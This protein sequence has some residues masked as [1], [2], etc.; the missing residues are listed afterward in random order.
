MHCI[1]L[2]RNF[3]KREQKLSIKNLWGRGGGGHPSID[4]KGG[5]MVS[6]VPPLN[7]AP[8]T[9]LATMAY[10]YA[11][12]TVHVTIFSTGAIFRTVSNFTEL[13]ALTQTTVLMYSCS[14]G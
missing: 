2:V 13:H 3:V 1:P 11:A 7:E 9:C 6:F 5:Q 8:I 12:R 4:S 14:V 10:A